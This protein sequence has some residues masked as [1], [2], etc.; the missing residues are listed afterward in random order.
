M[1]AVGFI[2]SSL[3]HDYIIMY[4]SGCDQIGT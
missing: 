1:P 3:L 4:V 2:A